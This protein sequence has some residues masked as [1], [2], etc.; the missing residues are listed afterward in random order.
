M[1]SEKKPENEFIVCPVCSGRGRNKYGLVCTNC[2]GMG[3]GTFY[4]GR[5][6]YWGPKLGRALIELSHL[7]TK[8][9]L[10]LNLAAYTIGALGFFALGYWAYEVVQNSVNIS[11]FAF[12]GRRHILLLIFWLSLIADM[13]VIYRISEDGRLS[14]KIK[15]FKY[16]DRV[17]KTSTPNNWSELIGAASK[18]KIDVAEGFQQKAIKIIEDAYMLAYKLNHPEFKPIHLFFTC[19]GDAEA[20]AIFT[21]L[22]VD[23][24]Q[25]IK[26]LKSRISQTEKKRDRTVLSNEIKE[27]LIDAYINA[28]KLGRKKVSPKNLLVPCLK[29]D[30]YL[31]EVLY[32][33]EVDIDKINNVILWF[34]I[35]EKQVE[36]YHI[37][38]KMARLKPGS[39]MDR[40]YTSVATPALSHFS[41]DLTLA[42][43]WGKLDFCV[44]RD[45][46]IK[47]VWQHFSGGSAG[48]LLVGPPGVGKNTVIDG[49]AQLMVRED[50]PKMFKD[51]RLV[52]LD[53]ARLISGAAPAEAEQRLLVILDEIRRAGNIVLYIN[54][55][56]N[57]MGI[58][59]GTEESLDLSEVLANALERSGLFCLAS[60]TER[61]YTKYF[62]GSPLENVLAKVKIAEPEGNQAIQ[63]LE[64]K[65]GRF[66][67]KYKVYFSYNAIEQVISLT[68]KYIHDKYLPKKAMD[69]LELVAV[70]TAKNKGEQSLVTR[71]DIAAVVSEITN[72]PVTKISESESQNLL[73]L[74]KL[75][76]QRMINQE[77][78]VNMVSAS[79]RR[80]RTQMRESK[81]PI[82][83]FLFLGPTGVGKTELAK[84][85]ADVYFGDEDYMIRLDMSEY[86]HPDS[87]QKMIG[88]ASGTVGYLTEAVR[89]APFSLILLDEFEK[90]HP[91]IM[92]LFL[93]VM[94]DGRLTDGQGRTVDFTNSILIATSNAG[95]VYI[96]K[97]IF[98]GTDINEIKQTLINEHLNKFM[99]PELINRFD[100]VIVFEPLSIENVV[101][102]AKLML[103]SVRQMLEEKG[104]SLHIEDEGV[105]KL[106]KQG[107]DPKF[108]ARPLRRLLQNKIE[109][110]IANRILSGELT[111]RDTVI[112]D[113]DAMV[114]IEKAKEL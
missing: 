97:E 2:A 52:E 35:N 63:I 44:A 24:G 40:A 9:K 23:G 84:S 99:R 94:D 53:V 45:E 67:G 41:H 57:L 54:D 46:E 85:I 79:L 5:F 58:T 91:D 17:K 106:A 7:K 70:R 86:Q 98:A 64:S 56:E 87:I 1:L 95:A 100:G 49:I 12:W 110:K 50:V 59:S 93:Q 8:F 112:I 18:R 73:N 83:N 108:G 104:I 3:T 96:E 72:I 66:E 47:R 10:I 69:I 33:F 111:R 80:A 11:D 36:N 109:D 6:F 20:G 15:Q 62:E 28:G 42:A 107:Y 92:N 32:D 68:K 30:E 77:E 81:R 43:K 76:H 29:R 90:A 78:A 14:K 65:I 19:L 102:I 113:A 71:E 105:R 103:N 31:K 60:I 48:V 101:E 25:L 88:S 37:Y 22:N 82:A 38:K 26:K 21:R 16:E 34:I 27:I 4:N 75:I 61:N 55:I 74:E 39:G 114:Q 51:K 89:K 13:F